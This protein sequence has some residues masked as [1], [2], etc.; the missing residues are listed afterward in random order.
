M[1]PLLLLHINNLFIHY[2][3]TYRYAGRQKGKVGFGCLNTIRGGKQEKSQ[4]EKGECE[5]GS[6]NEYETALNESEFPQNIYEK[7]S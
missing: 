6:L 2:L 4:K 5:A 1:Q 7:V 3:V